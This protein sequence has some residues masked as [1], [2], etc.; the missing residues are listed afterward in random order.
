MLTT[1]LPKLS[2]PQFLTMVTVAVA[3][4]AAV[5]TIAMPFIET[6]NLG[7]RMKAVSV[8]RDKIRARER[9]RLAKTQK[10]ASLRQEPKAYMKQV[11]DQFKL[12][13]WLGTENA[14]KQLTM[15]GYRGQQAEIA[16][17]FFRLVT[18]IGFTLT[19]LFY[20]FVLNVV[21]QPPMLRV[22]LVIVA[23]YLGIKAP[24]CSSPTRSRSGRR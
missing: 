17:L 13:D 16:F 15:A 23:A 20:L 11:V 24:R 4:A 3:A 1:L 10:H 5:V 19:A 2:D 12:G 21:D 7:R 14:K 8:E 9:D 6:D 22:G 18:P